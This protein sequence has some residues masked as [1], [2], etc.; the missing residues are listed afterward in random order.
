MREKMIRISAATAVEATP[1][2]RMSEP[3]ETREPNKKKVV[4]R[5]LTKE[6]IDCMLSIPEHRK[7][8][9]MVADCSTFA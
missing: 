2:T 1:C 6:E 4:R 8:F 3:D 9:P 7:P 5:K